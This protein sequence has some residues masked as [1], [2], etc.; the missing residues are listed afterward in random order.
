MQACGTLGR[1]WIYPLKSFPG[2]SVEQGILLPNGGLWGDRIWALFDDNGKV[3]NAKRTAAIHQ[4]EWQWLW[5]IQRLEVRDRR[6]GTGGVFQWA[7]ESSNLEEWLSEQFGLNLHLREDEQQGFPDDTA[8]SGPTIIST[9]T[10]ERVAD[11]FPEA[12]RSSMQARFRANLELTGVPPFGEDR[13]F[14]KAESPTEFRIGEASLLGINPCQ[15][16]AVPSRDPESGAEISGF[17]KTF[18]RH[19][20]AEL[21]GKVERSR[22]NHYYR[23]AV[24][25]QSAEA[26][27]QVIRVGDPVVIV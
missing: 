23:L 7:T 5:P 16:C 12:D 17:A 11:W 15:R 19:R 20:E 13:L 2:V 27:P 4:I 26:V 25:T 18:A 22:F 6:D 24:N 10:L 9:A 14:G 8:A 3:F 21:P 1:I